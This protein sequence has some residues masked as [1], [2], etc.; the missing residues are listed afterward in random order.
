VFSGCIENEYDVKLTPVGDSLERVLTVE[1]SRAAVSDDDVKHLS[2]EY[3]VR[4]PA[5]ARSHVFRG[6]FSGRMPNDVGGHGSFARWD[7]PLGSAAVYIE[8]F[9]GK[10]DAAGELI[11]RQAAADSLVGLLIGWLEL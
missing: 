4:P 6:R 11:R 1:H 5:S 8:R 3:H 9:R 7:T 10:D 2:E